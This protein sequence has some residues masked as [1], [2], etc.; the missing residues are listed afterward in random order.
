M[1][2]DSIRD[3]EMQLEEARKALSL[4]GRDLKSVDAD[5]REAG[6]K[7]DFDLPYSSLPKLLREKW[8]Q[9][10]RDT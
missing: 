3:F 6:I 1:K 5:D 2:Y 4:T 10:K 9:N 7:A 8:N